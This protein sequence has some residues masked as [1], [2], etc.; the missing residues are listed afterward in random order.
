MNSKQSGNLRFLVS[1][2]ENGGDN[3]NQKLRDIDHVLHHATHTQL[4]DYDLHFLI[5]DKKTLVGRL[6]SGT[7]IDVDRNIF[8]QD[9]Q[10][11]EIIETSW[12]HEIQDLD[13]FVQSVKETI[14]KNSF[15]NIR[16][17]VKSGDFSQISLITS[18]MGSLNWP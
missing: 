7:P 16:V 10:N 3:L 9:E 11:A 18:Q 4:V 8:T 2:L 1:P 17:K 15:E 5:S 6:I 14:T 12:E 13:G